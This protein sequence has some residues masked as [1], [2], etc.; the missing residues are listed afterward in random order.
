[1][2]E[3]G[4]SFRA[5]GP[6]ASCWET[7]DESEW[8]MTCMHR[9]TQDGYPVKLHV[10]DLS[11]GMARQLPATIVG[12]E[13]IEAIWYASLVLFPCSCWSSCTQALPLIE[14]KELCCKRSFF[15][16]S[17][18]LRKERWRIVRS[19]PSWKNAHGDAMFT[20]L[21]NKFLIFLTVHV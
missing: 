19:S 21:L 20:S 14:S 11:Q 15:F 8:W 1:M 10:Y 18:I 2:T 13:A 5:S 17:L 6:H 16:L 4:D 7:T 3:V 9:C 12:R